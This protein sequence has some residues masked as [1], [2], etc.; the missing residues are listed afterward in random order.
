MAYRLDLRLNFGRFI[1]DEAFVTQLCELLVRHAQKWSSSA[2][3]YLAPRQRIPVELTTP[4]SL[5]QVIRSLKAGPLYDSIVGPDRGVPRESFGFVEIRGK[6]PDLIGVVDYDRR[7]LRPIGDARIWGNSITI[8]V[9]RAKPQGGP[10]SRWARQFLIDAASSLPSLWYATAAMQEETDAKNL[11]Q[12]RGVRAIG[13]DISRALPGLYWLNYFGP[14]F[15][16]AIG[17]DKLLA[18]TDVSIERVE[19]GI[20]VQLSKDPRE[21]SSREYR[22]AER[23]TMSRIGE[24]WFFCRDRGY[25]GTHP[26]PLPEPVTIPTDNS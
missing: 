4:N 16:H 21:W 18:L 15:S 19:A 20:V 10:A 23:R 5:Y 2:Y 9:C 1:L 8:Q 13:V 25:S 11:D 14:R 22:D 7:L 3:V 26:L 12:S 6:T 24:K 17:K